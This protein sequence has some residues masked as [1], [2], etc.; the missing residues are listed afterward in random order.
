MCQHNNVNIIMLTVL[1][2]YY[3]RL[4]VITDATGSNLFNSETA[5][6]SLYNK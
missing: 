4:E 1:I 3:L 5:I 6:L 2:Q